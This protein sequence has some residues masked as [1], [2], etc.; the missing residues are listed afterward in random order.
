[1][2]SVDERGRAG[3]DVSGVEIRPARTAPLA[4]AWALALGAGLV[5]GIATS[6]LQGVLPGSWNRLANSG[7]VWT[8][9]AFAVAVRVSRNRSEA[10]GAGLFALLGS[11]AGYYA[12]ASP[13]RGIAT[14]WNE[15]LLWT[16]AAL[17]IGP[18][19]GF[20]ADLW[21]RGSRLPR[22]TGGLSM[23]G[24]VAGEGL[25]AIARISSTDSAGWVEFV[26][27]VAVAAVLCRDLHDRNDALVCGG[28]ALLTTLV[29][30]HGVRRR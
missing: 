1:M 12:V 14:S 15:R 22:L 2:T 13:L 10:V 26:V 25:H 23:C 28:I 20:A 21:A 30:V 6:Y 19:A 9:L 24:V 3:M 4:R 8:V 18:A 29:G 5:V 7:G 17:L 27:G 16:T 11:V